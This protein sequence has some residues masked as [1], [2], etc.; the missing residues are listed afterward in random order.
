MVRQVGFEPTATSFTDWP[1][2]PPLELPHGASGRNRT[3]NLA[4]TT[5]LLYLLSYASMIRVRPHERCLLGQKARR[6]FLLNLQVR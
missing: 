4:V 3:P 6:L 5:G 2:T 1:S